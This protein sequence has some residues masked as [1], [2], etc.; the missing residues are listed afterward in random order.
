MVFYKWQWPQPVLLKKPDDIPGLGFAV[1]DPRQNV[2]D[3]FH[4]MPIITPAYPQQNSTFNVSKS[5]LEVMKEE[6]RL[7]LLICEE[8][9]AGKA[10]WDK[11]FESPN[12]FLKYRHYIVL[13]ASSAT[14]ADQIQWYGHVES[15]VRHLVGD[16]ERDALELAHVWPKTYPSLEE[17]KEKT[18]CYWFIGLVIKGE[19][20]GKKE[21]NHTLFSASPLI[22]R[23]RIAVETTPSKLM[24]KSPNKIDVFEATPPTPAA[25]E[26]PANPQI[27]LDLTTPIRAFCELVMRS[28]ITNQMWKEGMCVE[29]F[30]KKRKQ[31]NDY[32]PLEERQKLKP[33]RKSVNSLTP[34]SGTGLNSPSSNN[35]TMSP[36]KIS[37]ISN[38]GTPQGSTNTTSVPTS[39]KRR[40]SDSHVGFESVPDVPNERSNGASQFELTGAKESSPNAEGDSISDAQPPS[41]RINTES[42]A[43]STSNSGMINGLE[44]S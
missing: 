17:G 24:V 18:T 28:A 15:K 13:E 11:L 41:K 40:P 12:F 3:R 7:S 43:S 30:Y 35:Q 16:L 6:F 38:S 21:E 29:A 44:V 4:L 19:K 23:D 5:T 31:L 34:N 1:W 33:E 25:G 9:I 27:N 2:S 14:E 22:Q 8:I 32:L 36:D 39:G 42:T 37:S 26:A 20:R 10:T